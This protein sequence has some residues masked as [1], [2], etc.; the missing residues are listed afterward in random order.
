[1]GHDHVGG[2]IPAGGRRGAGLGGPR[3]VK[4]FTHLFT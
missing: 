4:I 2:R 3:R 1:M